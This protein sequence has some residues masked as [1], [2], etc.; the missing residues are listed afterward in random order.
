MWRHS[1]ALA[2]VLFGCGG[3]SA[4]DAA[5]RGDDVAL[6]RAMEPELR[7]G[8]LT[9]DDAARIARAV[10]EHALAQTHDK[11]A[12]ETV[13]ELR[14]CASAL[15]SA[16]EDRMKTHDD[17]GAEAAMALLEIDELS[18]NS[19]REWLQ[20]TNDAWR[21]VG[22]RGLVR[23]SDEAARQRELVDPSAG[24]RRA[25]MRASAQAKAV[26]D[27]PGLLEAAR[28]DPDPMARNEA[29]RAVARIDPLRDGAFDVVQRLHDL[30]NGAD[31][32]LREDIAR[33]RTCRRTSRRRVARRSFVCF[34]RA[35]TGRAS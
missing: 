25:S 15:T 13:R 32:A 10:A 8:T 23:E 31:D 29:V 5:R 26:N 2:F 27:V 16:L 34:S 30:W 18:A 22:A 6:A 4:L 7:A 14:T 21:A 11:D 20:D 17:A 3:G 9:N 12:R 33:A 1:T 35:V 19:A 28:V 24:V